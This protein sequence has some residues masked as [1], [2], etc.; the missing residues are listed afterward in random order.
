M[1]LTEWYAIALG[2]VVGLAL[3]ANFILTMS[4][5]DWVGYRQCLRFIMAT[6][7]QRRSLLFILPLFAGNILALS[8][9]TNNVDTVIRRSGLLCLINLVPL[10][11]GGRMNFVLDH[12]GISLSDFA[13]THRWLGWLC[14]AQ[15]IMH[16]TA[17]F[18][19][20]HA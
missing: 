18:N 6:S 17:G 15:G 1:E 19:F 20:S 5:L 10:M 11:L 13:I 16:V 12:C 4:K 3:A 14:I 8:L 9:Y 7:A 2:A